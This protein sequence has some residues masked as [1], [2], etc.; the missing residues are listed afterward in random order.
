[1]WACVVFE[2]LLKVYQINKVLS[3]FFIF[4]S[5]QLEQLTQVTMLLKEKKYNSAKKNLPLK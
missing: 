5:L 1:M 2:Q 4:K 3:G